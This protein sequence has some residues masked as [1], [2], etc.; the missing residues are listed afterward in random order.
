MFGSIASRF[1]GSLSGEFLCLLLF[2]ALVSTDN[3]E[4][5]TWV[6]LCMKF[7]IPSCMPFR[8]PVDLQPAIYL[9]ALGFDMECF[10]C[11]HM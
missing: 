9:L 10:T 6:T 2:L 11:F 3:G 8:D 7:V 4:L 1:L 5:L